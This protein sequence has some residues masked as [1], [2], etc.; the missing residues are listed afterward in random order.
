MLQTRNGKRTAKSA[1]K[2]AVDLA[3]EGV[4]S[5]EEAI[6]RVE[7]SALDQLLHPTLD[8]DAAR[9]VVAAGLP[10]SPGAA[11]GKIVFD[12]DEAERAAGLGEA[13]I[14]VREE[15]SPGGHPRH[16]RGARHRHGAR[17]HDQPRGRCGARHGPGLR[18]RRRRN[19]YRRGQGS[20]HRARPHLQGRRDHHHRRLEGRG[21]GRRRA[22]DRTGAD[23]RLPDPH[24]LGRQGAPPE[25]PRQRRN[26]AGRQ[27][28]ARLRRRGH[29]P[30]PHRAH[31]L[32]RQP[33]RWPCA[34]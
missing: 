33:H 34:R 15:T 27:D 21:S 1:L 5:Q 32:R 28:R 14:L 25:G 12:A 10:A 4:I 2:I 19:P 20:L 7:P 8:P 6:S 31:V 23:R 29:R 26:P 9:T 17:R 3:E 22:D 18:V 13:V 11:T 30:V 16:A 24:G